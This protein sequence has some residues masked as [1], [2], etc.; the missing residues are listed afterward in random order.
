VRTFTDQSV[1]RSA[2]QTLIDAA[3]QAPSAMNA[4]PWAFVVIEDRG[5]LHEYADHAKA[6]YLTL[7]LPEPYRTEAHEILSGP[8]VDIFHGAPTLVVICA[9]ADHHDT[10]SD[11][12]LVAQNLMLGRPRCRPW[13]LPGPLRAPLPRPARGQGRVG[14]ST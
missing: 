5:L 2:V 9:R 8:G 11:C 7:E 4:Q 3:I 14:R 1:E 10:V 13:Q 12:F 6:H